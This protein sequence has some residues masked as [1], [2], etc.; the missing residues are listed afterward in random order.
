[1]VDNWIK[2]GLVFA[3]IL[4]F[5]GMSIIPVIESLSVEKNILTKELYYKFDNRNDNDTT[6]PVTTIYF[7]PPEPNG[8]NDWYVTNIEITLEAVD[9]LSG[10]DYIKYLLDDNDWMIYTSPLIIESDGYH[11]IT[12]YA[13]D[14]AGNV[15]EPS[16]LVRF[17]L[18]QTKPVITITY[19]WI[20]NFWSGY[21][22]IINATCNDT[23]SGMEKVEFYL[24]GF[25]QKIIMGDGPYYVWGPFHPPIT[26][27]IR[28]V[29]YDKAGNNDFK[30][31]KNPTNYENHQN[32]SHSQTVLKQSIC[33]QQI[34]P[35]F[36][37]IILCLQIIYTYISRGR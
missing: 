18:D 8:L 16:E 10:V 2:K 28:G 19:K 7:D 11:S 26:I 15:E 37:K 31:I 24:G 21:E 30:E 27:I 22:L 36:Q 3:V 23:T 4:F 14:K 32:Q 25:L 17:K 13:V 33:S 5:I 6:P 35:L 9:D 12:Y 34:N 20:G 1:M 29:A